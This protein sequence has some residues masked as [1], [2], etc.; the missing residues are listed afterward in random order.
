MKL[1][2]ELDYWKLTYHKLPNKNT[3][4]LIAE[5]DSFPEE[6]MKNVQDKWK[7]LGPFPLK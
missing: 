2:D 1:N 3:A 7:E 5:F 6:A 4:K